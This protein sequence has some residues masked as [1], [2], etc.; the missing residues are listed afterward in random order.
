MLSLL[1][2]TEEIIMMYPNFVGGFERWLDFNLIVLA[3]IEFGA[4]W[5]LCYQIFISVLPHM[6]NPIWSVH[7]VMACRL[8]DTV[9]GLVN[10]LCGFPILCEKVGGIFIISFEQ[11]VHQEPETIINNSQQYKPEKVAAAAITLVIQISNYDKWIDGLVNDIIRS[12]LWSC[13]QDDN[14]PGR[15]LWSVHKNGSHHQR[16]TFPWCCAWIAVEHRHPQSVCQRRLPI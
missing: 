6:R 1:D 12:P 15:K 11:Y 13:D 2:V 3:C 7:F 16:H 4:V 8:E 10:L 9:Q 5:E 14:N